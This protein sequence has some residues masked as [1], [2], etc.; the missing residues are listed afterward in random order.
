MREYT[1][2]VPPSDDYDNADL[3]YEVLQFFDTRKTLS[4]YEFDYIAKF[5]PGVDDADLEEAL[6]QIDNGPC[7]ITYDGTYVWIPRKCDLGDFKQDV[8]DQTTF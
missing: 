4:E 8:K 3:L 7:S 1:R 6:Q 2:V 5:F